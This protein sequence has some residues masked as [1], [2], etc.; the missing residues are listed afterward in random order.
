MLLLERPPKL[1]VALPMLPV[2]G[3]LGV[4]VA[5]RLGVVVAGRLGVVVC[6]RLVLL[7]PKLRLGVVGVVVCGRLGVA[8]VCVAVPV[9]LPK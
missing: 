8:G 5:G 2:V 3:R 6:G 4:V 7:P 9:P 1:R